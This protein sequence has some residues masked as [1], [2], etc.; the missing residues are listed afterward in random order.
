MIPEKHN[1][2]KATSRLGRWFRL[3]DNTV[4]DPKVQQLSAENFRGLVNLWCL[5][6]KNDGKIPSV[7]DVAFRLRM[8]QKKAE[9][10]LA[11]LT[12]AG[13]IDDTDEELTPHNWSSRQYKS[14]TSNERVQRH[15]ERKCNVT[16]TV[17]GNGDVTPYET[18]P[19][20]ETDS[21][22]DSDSESEIEREAPAAPA[23][24][25]PT[26]SSSKAISKKASP[27]SR[28]AND[29]KATEAD[30]DYAKTQGLDDE[31]I[32][33]VAADFHDYYLRVDD[34]KG[35]MKAW[36]A[37]WRSWVRRQ[38]KYDGGVQNIPPRGQQQRG[39]SAAEA[40]GRLVEAA[41]NGF[42]LTPRP[43]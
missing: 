27:A 19:E 14:D 37:A 22:S 36:D 12:A 38:I 10:I 16:S 32:A 43:L 41:Q 28:I 25:L 13:L 3:Y 17:T 30:V 23:P 39:G 20:S 40:A 2:V 15:R 31:Q 42:E 7:N 21:E 5:A 6:S 26:V 11:A 29:W 1:V 18:P 34:K 33:H 8:S 24:S 4:D 9:K 35:K